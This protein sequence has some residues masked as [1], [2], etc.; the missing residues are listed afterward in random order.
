MRDAQSQVG[1][2]HDKTQSLRP[3]CCSNG[4]RCQN[5]QVE[6]WSSTGSRTRRSCPSSR[7]SPS[8]C[9]PASR[10]SSAAGPRGSPGP[11]ARCRGRRRSRS[12]RTSSSWGSWLRG[13]RTSCRARAP[14]GPCRCS[15]LGKE[16][17]GSTRWNSRSPW[18][19]RST[20]ICGWLRKRAHGNWKKNVSYLFFL[21]PRIGSVPSK[22][23]TSD[24]METLDLQSN[25]DLRTARYTYCF[26]WRIT[27]YTYITFDIR[28]LVYVLDFD[29]RTSVFRYTTSCW[30]RD[31]WTMNELVKCSALSFQFFKFF[32][33]L[34]WGILMSGS[35]HAQPLQTRNWWLS[36]HFTV[37]STSFDCLLEVFR[38]L[39]NFLG[40]VIDQLNPFTCK[41]KG[42]ANFCSFFFGTIIDQW[43]HFTRKSMEFHISI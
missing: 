24:L 37:R 14:V 26:F 28:T 7:S 29:I 35:Q 10:R 27:L 38:N 3:S 1:W 11:P 15:A 30:W 32:H 22:P 33:L 16:R 34:V 23:L 6:R 31:C 36:F 17:C 12:C 4:C 13:I 42:L 39:W 8:S 5:W 18:T 43:N 19:C 9:R 20:G 21:L 41:S 40:K 2:T 25:L